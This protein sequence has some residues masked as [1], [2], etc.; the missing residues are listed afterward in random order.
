MDGIIVMYPPTIAVLVGFFFATEYKPLK[1]SGEISIVYNNPWTFL[2]ATVLG[3]SV[4]ASS[5]ALVGFRR[6]TSIPALFC[7][8]AAASSYHCYSAKLTTSLLT[9]DDDHYSSVSLTSG[10]TIKLLTHVRNLLLV[11]VGIIAFHDSLTSQEYVGY[12]VTLVGLG[13]YTVE[14]NRPKDS[15]ATPGKEK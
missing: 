3:I 2:S 1:E 10:L 11:A 7:H 9:N 5:V 4:N 13:W 6:Q 8:L 15:A 14:R 12:S